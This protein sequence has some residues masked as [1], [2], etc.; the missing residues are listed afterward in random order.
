M[1]DTPGSF[2]PASGRLSLP[3][4]SLNGDLGWNTPPEAQ[5]PFRFQLELFLDSRLLASRRIV[6][7]EEGVNQVSLAGGTAVGFDG[8]VRLEF[9]P[10]A[11][12]E[13]LTVRVRRPAAQSLPPIVLSGRP[14]EVLAQ[15]QTSAADIHQFSKPITV[16]LEYDPQALWGAEEDLRLYTYDPLLKDWA[17][18]PSWVDTANHRLIGWTDHF[19]LVDY[20]V[21]QANRLSGLKDFQVSPSTGAAT[22]ALPLWTPPGPGG[23]QPS[24]TLTYNSQEVDSARAGLQASWAGMGW[25]L[26]T[27]YIEPGP[28]DEDHEG[29]YVVSTAGVSG[30]LAR[31]TDG[32]YHTTHESFW[33]FAQSS[34]GWTAWDKVG[35]QYFFEQKL[36]YPTGGGE[37]CDFWEFYVWRWLLTRVRNIYGQEITYTYYVETENTTICKNPH[38]SKPVDHGAYPATI[39]YPNQRYQI[40]F[41]RTAR[42]DYKSTWPGS[43]ELFQKSLLSQV[44]ILR[45]GSSSA[46]TSSPTTAIPRSFPTWD[47][48]QA[49]RRPP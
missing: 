6:V 28:D 24:L 1:P 13:A 19:S 35:N 48:R 39:T 29:T 20:D 10:G 4:A 14:I 11:A 3:L 31:G 27:G 33:R 37:P 30:L 18:L 7:E 22:Y 5:G 38:I 40:V 34:N 41:D 44:R 32:Y 26:D 25:S 23:L 49:A 15:G 46:A 42:T 2:D 36:R 47:G 12:A 16:T 21:L 9:P 45:E 17:R 8:R 43:P